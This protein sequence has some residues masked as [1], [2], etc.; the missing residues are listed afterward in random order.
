L[1]RLVPDPVV[2]ASAGPLPSATLHE[3]TVSSGNKMPDRQR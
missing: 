2:V 1:I 3:S